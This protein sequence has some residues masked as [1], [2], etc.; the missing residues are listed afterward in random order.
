MDIV[1]DRRAWAESVLAFACFI[2]KVVARIL[3]CAEKGL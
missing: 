3:E 2:H 1:F